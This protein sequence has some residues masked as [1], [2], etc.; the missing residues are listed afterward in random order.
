[1]SPDSDQI[2]LKSPE[3]LSDGEINIM[4]DRIKDD[5]MFF[6]EYIYKQKQ[7]NDESNHN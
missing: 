2:L 5:P 6:F 1:M 3:E 7:V 4:L